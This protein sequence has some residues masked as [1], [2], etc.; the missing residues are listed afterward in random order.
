MLKWR[1]FINRNAIINSSLLKNPGRGLTIVL[2]ALS[3][4]GAVVYYDD[5]IAG[6]VGGGDRGSDRG[7]HGGD[8]GDRGGNDGSKDGAAGS[9]KNESGSN[10]SPDPGSS[11]Q[12]YSDWLSD[13]IRE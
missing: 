2:F 7:G 9:A 1:N 11:S 6:K 8:R 3:T 12:S 13:L 10:T 5:A 4:L